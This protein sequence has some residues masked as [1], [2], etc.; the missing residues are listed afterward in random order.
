MSLGY[1]L[2]ELKM[3]HLVDGPCLLLEFESKI[4]VCKHIDDKVYVSPVIV[5][6]RFREVLNRDE[7][8]FIV[9]DG[10]K[11]PIYEESLESAVKQHKIFADIRV[12]R[13]DPINDLLK[14]NNIEV[15]DVSWLVS[16]FK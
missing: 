14:E 5:K 1:R 9:V 4:R 2:I 10:E 6:S 15:H 11:Y 8:T 13:F 12:C 7:D 3:T 16:P